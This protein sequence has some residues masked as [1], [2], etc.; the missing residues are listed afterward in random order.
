MASDEADQAGKSGKDESRDREL[1]ERLRRLDE[2][3]GSIKAGEA[4]EAAKAR[5]QEGDPSA[6]GKAMR[7]SSEFVGGI[8]A[9]GLLGWVVD[10]FAGTS[11]WGLIIFLML[12]FAA[13]VRNL[14]RA[15]NMLGKTP[16]K[17]E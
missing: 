17:Q 16:D 8:V 14:L 6:I 2:R 5:K 11:P 3:L 1:N 15:S 13:G 7:L 9:G 10:R 12:G 4:A